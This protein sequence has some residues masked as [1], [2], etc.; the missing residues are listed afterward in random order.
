[1]NGSIGKLAEQVVA[2]VKAGALT[3][4]AE[5]AIMDHVEAQATAQT[6]LGKAMLK[7]ATALRGKASSDITIDELKSFIEGLRE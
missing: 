3:K 4:L 6:D 5:H 2:E 1:M 7:L